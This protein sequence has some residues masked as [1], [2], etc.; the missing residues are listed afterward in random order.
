[1]DRDQEDKVQPVDFAL[2][3]LDD[4]ITRIPDILWK[5]KRV[6]NFLA[7]INK[8]AP[9][10]LALVAGFLEPGLQLTN[11]TAV[12]Q[13]WRAIL[14]SF[15][16]LWNRI[17]SSDWTLFEAYLERSKSIPLKVRVVQD[18]D[19]RVLEQLVP[20]TSRLVSLAVRVT[21]PREFRWISRYLQHP[22]PAVRKLSV[23]ARP[24]VGT[25]ELS[26]GFGTNQLLNVKKLHVD[27][28]FSLRSPHPF[29]HVT[30]LKWNAGSHDV[31]MVTRFLDIMEK[32][33][34][35]ERVEVVFGIHQRYTI[36]FDQPPSVVTV[37]HLEWMS[38]HCS[39]S[40]PSILRF[41]KLPKLMS[42]VV[43][44]RIRASGTLPIFPTT[45][46]GK[47]LP[48]FTELPEMEVCI[49]EESSRITFRA[50]SQAVLEYSA[51]TKPLGEALYRNDRYFWGDLPLHSVRKLIVIM[52]RSEAD[53]ADVWLTGLLRDLRSLEHLELRGCCGLFIQYLRQIVIQGGHFR[54]I[55]TLAVRSGYEYEMRQALRLE[56]VLDELG[57]G[58]RVTCVQDPEM[59]D[60]EPW[61][62]EAGGASESWA[63][64]QQS[65][66]LD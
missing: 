61:D 21:S 60:D 64:E 3:Q 10:T 50:S 27:A 56:T 28:I 49:R 4:A 36:P 11:A 45:P 30:E 62:P 18:T 40:I 19:F 23:T 35:L 65:Q 58:I 9:E 5:A 29:P 42:L 53:V 59:A 2:P 13:R 52:D 6:K 34:L 22:F 41:L 43:S 26:P 57:L 15:P 37:P 31:I 7:P 24:G 33:P 17:R 14:L 47:H 32:L 38:L 39:Q 48:N 25:L 1:M 54:G 8:L 16:R 66:E 63:Q 55:K 51:P 46:L 12:C 20:H 44:G